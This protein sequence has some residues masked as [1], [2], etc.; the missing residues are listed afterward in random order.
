MIETGRTIGHRIDA[1]GDGRAPDAVAFSTACRSAGILARPQQVNLRAP[2][3]RERNGC[4]IGR[5]VDA[6]GDGRAPDAVAF[7]TACRSAGDGDHRP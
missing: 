2:G 6:A 7:S 3:L 4:I 1:A 5:R